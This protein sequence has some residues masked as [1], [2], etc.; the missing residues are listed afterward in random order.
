MSMM[1]SQLQQSQS[2]ALQQAKSQAEQSEQFAQ[3]LRGM[4]ETTKQKTAKD[5]AYYTS[6]ATKEQLQELLEDMPLLGKNANGEGIRSQRI[7]NAT[8]RQMCPPALFGLKKLRQIVGKHCAQNEKDTQPKNVAPG[9]Y[10]NYEERWRAAIQTTKV[11]AAMA[12]AKPQNDRY[13]AYLAQKKADPYG[14]I[15]VVHEPD[16]GPAFEVFLNELVGYRPSE[17]AKDH[18]EAWPRLDVKRL[19]FKSKVKEFTPA[20]LWEQFGLYRMEVVQVMRE[21]Y[22]VQCLENPTTMTFVDDEDLFVT[23]IWRESEGQHGYIKFWVSALPQH[24]IDHITVNGDFWPT[25]HQEWTYDHFAEKLARYQTSH[26]KKATHQDGTK[27]SKTISALTQEIAALKT[28]DSK[29]PRGGG[30]DRGKG[31][32]GGGKGGGSDTSNWEAKNCL[33]GCPHQDKATWDYSMKT[34]A[35]T[36]NGQAVPGADGKAFAE[37]VCEVCNCH[38][39]LKG[40]HK[41]PP[42]GAKM[43]TISADY[44]SRRRVF[45]DRFGR[46]SMPSKDGAHGKGK[47][48]GGK[49]KWN[50]NNISALTAKMDQM[51][52]VLKH[53]SDVNE[54][55]CDIGMIAA[56]HGAACAVGP[57]GRRRRALYIEADDNIKVMVDSGAEVD[58]I[59]GRR[60]ANQLLSLGWFTTR[61]A[62][63]PTLKF[64]SY[65]KNDIGYN[66]DLHGVIYAGGRALPMPYLRVCD[67][68]PP[69]SF[70]I[71]NYYLDDTDAMVDWK[72]HT[73]TF[74]LECDIPDLTLNHITQWGEESS[75][76]A[77]FFREHRPR[78][79]GPCI[80][81]V[82]MEDTIMGAAVAALR[83]FRQEAGDDTPVDEDAVKE[84][85]AGIEGW[86]VY[87]IKQGFVPQ[88]GDQVVPQQEAWTNPIHF[89]DKKLPPVVDMDSR[90]NNIF[91]CL[92]QEEGSEE[93]DDDCPEL[94]LD[95]NRRQRF[96]SEFSYRNMKSVAAI[97]DRCSSRGAIPDPDYGPAFDPD[98]D[99]EYNVSGGPPGLVS[100]DEIDDQLTP[101]LA[102]VKVSGPENFRSGAEDS[103][104]SSR[105]PDR[106]GSIPTKS[107]SN[108]K[109]AGVGSDGATKIEVNI[110]SDIDA[111]PSSLNPLKPNKAVKS[112]REIGTSWS[113]AMLAMITVGMVGAVEQLPQI[114][115][116]IK[117]VGKGAKA[118]SLNAKVLSCAALLATAGITST[119]QHWDLH[120]H[121]LDE[122]LLPSNTASEVIYGRDHQ[123]RYQYQANWDKS[124]HNISVVETTQIPYKSLRI[125]AT[126]TEYVD[127][128]TRSYTIP[129]M[130]KE[131]EGGDANGSVS[132]ATQS[133]SPSKSEEVL[134][135]AVSSVRAWHQDNKHADPDETEVKVASNTG[136]T[137]KWE[138]TG[139][140]PS[141]SDLQ[142]SRVHAV[143][144][145][146]MSTRGL[147]YAGEAK[148]QEESHSQTFDRF[149]TAIGIKVQPT[150]NCDDWGICDVGAVRGTHAA[151]QSSSIW[152]QMTCDDSPWCVSVKKPLMKVLGKVAK[153]F[154]TTGK[155]PA[156]VDRDG[157][158]IE[159]AINLIDDAPVM[160]R[161]WRLSPEKQAVLDKYLD[162]LLERGIIQP[163][164]YASYATTTILVPKVGQKNSDGSQ[165]M[166]VVQDYRALNRKIRKL[167]YTGV[168]AQELF[169]NIGEAKLF[170]CWDISEAFYS[171][172]VKPKDTPKTTFWGG[173]RGLFEYLRVPMGLSLAPQALSHEFM[174]IWR[175]PVTIGGVHY[176]C[177]L[178]SVVLVYLDDVLAYSSVEDHLE[179]VD[180]VMSTMAKHHLVVRADKSYV[181]RTELTYLGMKLSAK[182]GISIDPNKVKACWE[183][184]R[185]KDPAGVRRFLGMCGYLR[186]FVPGFGPNSINLTATLRKGAKWEWTEACEKEYQYLLSCIAS[187]NCLAP[188]NWS[189]HCYL[190]VDSS[191]A[192]YGAVLTQKHGRL[193]RPVVWLSKQLNDTES[194][195][196]SRDLEAGAIC[197]AAQKLRC[198]LIT[199]PFTVMNDNSS[200]QWLHKYQG[201]NRRL[202]NYAMILSDYQMS[203][204]WT[205][206]SRM[207]EVDWASRAAL[208]ADPN[209]P[210]DPDR[211]IDTDCGTDI[212]ANPASGRMINGVEKSIKGVAKHFGISG[213][214]TTASAQKAGFQYGTKTSLDTSSGFEYQRMPMGLTSGDVNAVRARQPREGAR[215]TYHCSAKG[216]SKP[217]ICPGT[218]PQFRLCPD[219][220]LYCGSCLPRRFKVCSKSVSVTEWD[221]HSLLSSEYKEPTHWHSELWNETEHANDGSCPRTCGC[222]LSRTGKWFNACPVC[223]EKLWGN[224]RPNWDWVKALNSDK[225][226]YNR[227]TE[228]KPARDNKRT[229]R[230]PSATTGNATPTAVL[231]LTPEVP[232]RVKTTHGD[233]AKFRAAKVAS[234]SQMTSRQPLPSAPTS[235]FKP[236]LPTHLPVSMA[237]QTVVSV[238]TGIGVDEMI[239]EHSEDWKLVADCNPDDE[240]RPI[241]NQRGDQEH[242]D[243]VPAMLAQ[244]RKQEPTPLRNPDVL[245]V[246]LDGRFVHS[247]DVMTLVEQAGPKMVVILG[248]VDVLKAGMINNASPIV[249]FES[250]LHD[251]GFIVESRVM[252][253]SEYGGGTAQTRHVCLAHKLG[254][255][256]FVWPE[257]Y[258]KFQ[259]CKFLQHPHT[260]DPT[261]RRKGYQAVETS[262][263]SE[264]SPSRVGFI[265]GGGECRNVYSAV[266]HPLPE[267]TEDYDRFT[268]ENGGQ[269]VLDSEG[270]RGL[271]QVE[272]MRNLSFSEAAIDQLIDTPRPLAQRC[273]GRATCGTIMASI[274]GT[275]QRL[276]DARRRF[277]V[278]PEAKMPTEHFVSA[279]LAH[280]VM[281]TLDEIKAAQLSDPKLQAVSKYVRSNPKERKLSEVPSEYRRHADFI[282]EQN[283]ALFYRDILNDEWLTNAV[284]LPEALIPK[285]LE[286]YHDSGYGCH[287][288]QHKTRIAMQERV[289]FPGM[290]QAVDKHIRDC[291]ACSRAKA[292]KRKHAGKL[293]S[294]IYLQPFELVGI[295]LVGPFLTSANGNRYVMHVIDAHTNWNICVALPNKE[296]AT[297]AK[298]FHEHVIIGGPCV[299]PVA[300]LSDRG[301]EFLNTLYSELVSQ[302]QVRHLKTSPYHPQGNSQCERTHRTL[303]AIFKT[304]LHK[305]GKDFEEALP[306]AT[307]CINTHA[308]DGTNISPFEMLYGRKP[309]DPNSVAATD[310]PDFTM[311]KEKMSSK[312]YIRMLRERMADVQI[313]VGLARLEV[314]R[315][316]R[317]RMDKVHYEY[318]YSVGDLVLRWTGNTKRGLYGKLAYTTTGPFEIVGIHPRNPDVYD[319]KHLES[320][321]AA[322][323]RHHVRELCPYISKE[324]HEKQTKNDSVNDAISTL[325][326]K[327]GDFLMLPYGR[328]NFIV[329]VLSYSH[330]SVRI[331]YLNKKKGKE[332]TK[333]PLTNLRLAW[334]KNSVSANVFSEGAAEEYEEIYADKL[335]NSQMAEGFRPYIDTLTIDA[336]Y[337]RIVA[338]GDIRKTKSGWTLNKTKA[339]IIKK[340]K[341]IH[342]RD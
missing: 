17:M 315:S 298:A 189:K 190:R 129:I 318:K 331:H 103:T 179:V 301:T 294:T 110:D 257:P 41:D 282:Q 62:K 340:Y 263:V 84:S 4:Q 216:Q 234:L 161:Q 247:K 198:Y 244:L 286:A 50:N 155:K 262:E 214:S 210:D 199:K 324:A 59:C 128:E 12:A 326:P 27:L 40:N 119:D 102:A 158:V 260:V 115:P 74:R 165:R 225:S 321:D 65:T 66:E 47:P 154:D 308:I 147:Q 222:C 284:V 303:G 223:N 258:S 14:D 253:A 125:S 35:K 323:T 289:F 201:T 105:V 309:A 335:T 106:T 141:A 71:G 131:P 60:M 248:P 149:I 188:F 342:Q 255:I 334:F 265:Q 76:I 329:Q 212:V 217:P 20:H 276:F 278:N 166:R 49:P 90:P 124:G 87:G 243:D 312:E 218:D 112:D 133:Y 126:D 19:Q 261:V 30:R 140:D 176:P 227:T 290:R 302:F 252:R 170:S 16:Y 183:A 86:A 221:R 8:L 162:E 152:D 97:K 95:D 288:G 117:A 94:Q 150:E 242:F 235:I 341:P 330:G 193:F 251:R 238:G 7:W 63:D 145:H 99:V 69:D 295:D 300:C 93:S 25:C 22:R 184:P 269:Y 157:K 339:T 239:L 285:A 96:R 306:Y 134:Q 42:P 148:R 139:L 146:A 215:N 195:R 38:G 70:L 283:G 228:L 143:F 45:G 274:Y 259:G 64:N 241:S 130:S 270:P 138:V 73:V 291:A 320:I 78:M 58:A 236:K 310:N 43:E 91:S 187:D 250:Q 81:Q 287:L 108:V 279:L 164:K 203:F 328:Q 156:M 305:Y 116:S 273:I 52:T 100:E 101:M 82:A 224:A 53:L 304:M 208:P 159:I 337:Q 132:W 205:K 231:P 299:C 18:K 191:A 118:L 206:G 67:N 249:Q 226:M 153:L 275:V 296:A 122:D 322:A 237:K 56:N 196:P 314:K 327:V 220:K 10:T 142:T 123:R 61:G 319:L 209:D 144:D 211:G 36:A 113:S 264:F 197:W 111:R 46:K 178:G 172:K 325:E 48:S 175:V 89:D 207:A 311:E 121:G 297:I 15:P 174:D 240:T 75:S 92:Q 163:T 338:D 80:N 88:L 135:Q 79:E 245:T 200:L 11:K 33:S 185:P 204:Q 28:Y 293:K 37:Q 9:L 44:N 107:V 317:V 230:A 137:P 202:W 267:F 72:F 313:A 194:N 171:L 233:P 160:Q 169:D 98:R 336:F 256:D 1:Q 180:F 55:E 332:K 151:D 83:A 26:M 316:T 173:S 181:G 32:G 51:T 281:P 13:A 177:A 186:A 114:G 307:Y 6:K 2:M 120:Q 192:G 24:F 136:W 68:A 292:V 182:C 266:D 21:A 333:E 271:V 39:H 229:A 5:G 272:Q 127:T 54:I 57:D 213:L 34:P 277:R 29:A 167:A 280:A 254:Q 85:A 246:H 232:R 77:A 31:G 109:G 268:G 3:L 219:N 168:T 23:G 104:S